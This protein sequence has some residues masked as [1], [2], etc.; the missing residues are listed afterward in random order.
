MAHNS[1]LTHNSAPTKKHFA[2]IHQ[3]VIQCGK[4]GN[5]D[6]GSLTSVPETFLF[7]FSTDPCNLSVLNLGD[8]TK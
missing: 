7:A 1:G 6:F 2:D 5:N 3:E 4:S 8:G